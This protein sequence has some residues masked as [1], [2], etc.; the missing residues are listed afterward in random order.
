MLHS[1]AQKCEAENVHH[2]NL[3]KVPGREH[4]LGQVSV[5]H[6]MNIKSHFTEPIKCKDKFREDDRYYECLSCDTKQICYACSIACHQEHE[7]KYE[8]HAKDNDVKCNCIK[9]SCFIQK[10]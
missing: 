8:T 5:K 9:S 4:I 2:R 1:S 10:Y 3:K 7:T 6:A